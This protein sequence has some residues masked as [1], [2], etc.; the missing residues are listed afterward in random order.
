M[1]KAKNSN[2][3]IESVSRGFFRI[4]NLEFF[5][6]SLLRI[7][8]FIEVFRISCYKSQLIMQKQFFLNS[9]FA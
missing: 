4:E 9:F 1:F 8:L 3:A 6:S 5:N 2:K 7:T